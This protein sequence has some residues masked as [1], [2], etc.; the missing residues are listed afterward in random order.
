MLASCTLPVIPYLGL[1]LTDVTFVHQGNK[2]QINDQSLPGVKL[3][4]M[5][6]CFRMQTILSSIA[7]T[8][9]VG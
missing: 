8:Q 2:S 1:A 6:K 7:R 4:N 9:S 3:I 5:T